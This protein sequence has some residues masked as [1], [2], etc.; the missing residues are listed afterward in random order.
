MAAA[1]API[2]E[3]AARLAA[4]PERVDEILAAGAA[5]ARAI[6][7][8]TLREARERMGFLPRPVRVT[9]DR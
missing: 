2:R 3:R 4:A 9:S 7:R 6:A 8:E 1:L 5:R